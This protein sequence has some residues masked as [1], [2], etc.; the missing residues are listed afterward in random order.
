M[1]QAHNMIDYEQ[2]YKDFKLEV[3]EYFNFS[4][5][6]IDKWAKDPDKLAMLWVDD[7]SNEVKKTFLD[8]STASKKLAS[9]C[10]L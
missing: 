10:T 9:Y 7:A 6:V 3:P 1:S 8:I 2:T 4:G 5:D